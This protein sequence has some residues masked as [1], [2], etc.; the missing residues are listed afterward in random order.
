MTPSEVPRL[1]RLAA[2]AAPFLRRISI[3]F[4]SSPPAS[5]SAFLT[6]IIGAPVRSRSALTS[7]A[8]TAIRTHPCPAWAPARA[9]A[10]AAAGPLCPPH[11]WP[12]PDRPCDRGA[13]RRLPAVAAVSLPLPRAVPRPVEPAAPG[14]R[15]WPG[16]ELWHQP[17]LW[18]W[19]PPPPS[20]SP[21]PPVW[22]SPPP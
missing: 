10:P 3:A 2:D 7:A 20:P 18:P 17:L 21:P 14:S 22:P 19:P 11:G 15:P 1:L 16:P 4:C 8:L 9:P 5:S 12:R 6:S 13:P